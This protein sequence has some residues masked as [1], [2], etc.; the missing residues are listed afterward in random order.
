MI[1][2]DPHLM[3]LARCH[4]KPMPGYRFA[5]H[6][7]TL[8]A[9]ADSVVIYEYDNAIYRYVVISQDQYQTLI[10]NHSKL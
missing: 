2:P 10:Q 6:I 4:I 5:K 9:I 8:K 3:A 7:T 1:I